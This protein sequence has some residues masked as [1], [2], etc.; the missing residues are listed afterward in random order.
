MIKIHIFH[1]G[2]VRVDTAIPY[3]EKNPL[4]VTGFLRGNDKKTDLPVSCY[5]I[6]HPNGRVLIDS[7]WH[8]KYANAPAVR[9]E[10]PHRF[11]GLLDSI[12]TPILNDGESI[13]CQLADM[14][15]KP[16][17]IDYLFPSH[18]DFDHT[19]GL[20]LLRGVPSIRAASEEIADAGR[21]FFRYVKENW[22]SV[23]LKPFYYEQ[24]GIGPVGKSYDVF[25]DG[26]I[27]L[28]NTPGHS[29][30]HFSAV[31]KNNGKYVVLAGDAIYTQKSMQDK[32]IP[33][34]TVNARLA[35]KSLE[36]I[37]G[38]A[39]DEN[40]LLVAAN[41]DPGITPQIIEL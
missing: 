14:G 4:A 32:L 13:D 15:V 5:L 25:G 37:C 3:K 1:T 22:K 29:H 36:W 34:F 9:W 8:S 19:S 7:G 21:Y 40:C 35:R 16:F 17:E 23:G 12:S 27:L 6:E 39:S 38:C 20:A 24:T 31:I 28:V 10:K 18:L 30:G 41:H 26:S 11:F 2:K 33:G